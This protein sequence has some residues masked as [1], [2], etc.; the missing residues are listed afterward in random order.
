MK[1]FRIPG[2]PYSLDIDFPI[3]Q[4]ILIQCS[5]VDA[6]DRVIQTWRKPIDEET[7]Q[8]YGHFARIAE[9]FIADLIG[10]R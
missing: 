7:W 4:K 9:K 3:S 2:R 6:S 5:I 8:S 1:P 10:R